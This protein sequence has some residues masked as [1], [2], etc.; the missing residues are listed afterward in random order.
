MMDKIMP[1]RNL[2]NANKMAMSI[3]NS[4]WGMRET[5]GMMSI[6]QSI[7][8]Q[9]NFI[10]PP[11]TISVMDS[12]VNQHKQV[13]SMA[14]SIT[15]IVNSGNAF[16]Q[17]S[18]LQFALQ[19]ITGKITGIA[20]FQQRWDLIDDFQEISNQALAISGNIEDDLA[21]TE[22]DS[23]SFQELLTFVYSVIKKH[24]KVGVYS[25]IFIDMVL[26]IASFHQYYD[27]LKSKPESA[28][29]TDL[30]KFEEILFKALEEKL[31]SEKEYRITKRICKVHLK[32]K[33]KSVVLARLKS[34]SEVIVLQVT[35]K[36]V[37]ISYTDDDNLSLTGWVMKKYLKVP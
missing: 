16:A 19:N 33:S 23:K 37:Y 12:I 22:E 18:S 6:S 15:N 13:W 29:K 25:I 24:R 5:A 11:K 27:F 10:I 28:T 9:L 30:V 8:K 17:M 1:H 26:R 4:L 36:W 34:D 35:A 2:I 3:T 32:P 31:K 21:L 14:N 20:T 7:Q